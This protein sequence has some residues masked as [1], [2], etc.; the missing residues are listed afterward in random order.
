MLL[1]YY[2]P[3]VC[4]CVI[5]LRCKLARL[6]VEV[7]KQTAERDAWLQYK[8]EGSMKDQQKIQKLEKRTVLSQMTF[9]DISG[10]CFSSFAFTAFRTGMFIIKQ[11]LLYCI[12]LWS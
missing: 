1:C 11:K 3:S 8:N 5:E 9:H 7:E 4:V 2:L 12:Q 10:V 6:Q